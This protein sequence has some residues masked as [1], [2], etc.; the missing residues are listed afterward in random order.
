MTLGMC[1]RYIHLFIQIL[2]NTCLAIKSR[3]GTGIHFKKGQHIVSWNI[4]Y[5]WM[6]SYRFNEAVYSAMLSRGYAGEPVVLDGF[7]MRMRDYV[8]LTGAALVFLLLL[9]CDR[10]I[11][12]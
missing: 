9:Y 4:A 5:L 2:E 11:L 10:R 3:T 6:R 7:R 12:S 8:W 1:Y